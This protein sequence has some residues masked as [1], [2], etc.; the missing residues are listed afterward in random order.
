MNAV[1]TEDL[2][3]RYNGAERNA[4]ERVNFAQEKGRH[5]V[6]FG[7]SGSGRSTLI[8]CIART[9]PR[10][11]PG[12]LEGKVFLFEKDVTNRSI[13]DVVGTVGLVFED[14]ENQLFCASVESETAFGPESLGCGIEE[15]E[16]RV[17][18]ALR[19]V[20]LESLRRRP[21]WTLSGGQK[22]RLAIAA[23]VAMKP[24]LLLLDEVTSQ[25]DPHAKSEIMKTIMRFREDFTTLAAETETE[26]GIDADTVV[27]MK[28]GRVEKR[29]SP[30]EILS[31]NPTLRYCG[32]EPLDSCLLFEMLGERERPLDSDT[33]AEILIQKGY[34]VIQDACSETTDST[35]GETVVSVDGLWHRYEDGVVALKNISVDFYRGELVALIGEN[36]SGKT[37]LAK[38]MNGLLAPTEGSVYVE[39]KRTGDYSGN[40]LQRICAY[41]FQNPDEQLFARSAVEEVS[42]GLHNFGFRGSELKERLNDALERVGL[43]EKAEDDPRTFTLGEKQRIAI[44]SVVAYEPDVLIL[45]EPT[46][47]LDISQQREVMEIALDARRRGT[48][49]I[50]ITHSMRLVA[51]Y[52]DRVVALSNGSLLFNGGVREL[53]SN[54]SLLEKLHLVPPQITRIGHRFNTTF[55][56]VEEATRRFRKKQKCGTNST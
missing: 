24:Q 25:L 30:D 31:D 49:V 14:F 40:E 12:T 56:S 9:A 17:D 41:L 28:N 8:N 16:K 5:T 27:I 7:T 46:T 32:V 39:G 37:T 20:G 19:M 15:I 55:L 29:G 21:P 23:T 48:C 18:W 38:H 3:F 44:A 51:E 4:I 45:D 6:L 53:F 26:T 10:H 34:E 2:S 42:F 47:G 13:T 33:T 1:L 50:L 54:R 22:Q 35:V 36:G 11:F 43:L 52:C